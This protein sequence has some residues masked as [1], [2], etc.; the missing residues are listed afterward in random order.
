MGWSNSSEGYG[1]LTKFFHWA[2]AL[3][4][5]FQFFSASIMVRLPPEGSAFGATQAGY[6]NW[7]KSIGL[8]ALLLAF[9]RVMARRHGN[10]P[11][12]AP[13]LSEME[14]G[15]IH[16]AEQ[17]LYVAMFLM[18]VSGF[19]YVMSGGYGVLLF[20]VRELPN[21]IGEHR[22]LALAAKWTHVGASYVLMVAL[23]GHIGLVLR[24]QLV[25]RDGLLWRML[26]R[27]RR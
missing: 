4:F 2:V 9:G 7:H 1:S 27:W 5:A 21:I 10:L 17:V 12:W 22:W 24:H 16:R 26:P 15:F 18:P 23:A 3:L 13:T 11:N 6:Y 20:G 25:L 19:L 8:V 14:R